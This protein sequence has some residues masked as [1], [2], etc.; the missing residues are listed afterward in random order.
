MI[1]T[2]ATNKN[3]LNFFFYI[4]LPSW[5]ALGESTMSVIILVVLAIIKIGLILMW[6]CFQFE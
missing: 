4:L 1:A 5:Y 2:L 3:S 6:L